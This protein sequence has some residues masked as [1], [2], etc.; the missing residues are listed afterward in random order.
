MEKLIDALQLPKDL[1]LGALNVRLIG[2]YEAYIENYKN[3]IEYNDKVICLQ[4]KNSKVTING[5]KL[6]IVCFSKDDMRIKG[7]IHE[8]IFN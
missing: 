8:V 5:E 1:M 4:G 3:I 2:K 6:K 7:C